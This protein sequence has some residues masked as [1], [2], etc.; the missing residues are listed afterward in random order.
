MIYFTEW[1]KGCENCFVVF[2]KLVGCNVFIE[3]NNNVY[4]LYDN[5][6]Y[7]VQHQRQHDQ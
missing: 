4:Y 3:Y 2:I 1:N 7:D 5:I 6:M